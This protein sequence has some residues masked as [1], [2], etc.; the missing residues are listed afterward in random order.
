MALDFNK[1]WWLIKGGYDYKL[2]LL[3]S[4]MLL[5]CFTQIGVSWVSTTPQINYSTVDSLHNLPFGRKKPPTLSLLVFLVTSCLRI[6]ISNSQLAD[7]DRR[8]QVRDN[9]SPIGRT[10]V[11]H[12]LPFIFNLPSKF[13]IKIFA[14]SKKKKHFPHPKIVGVFSHP[15]LPTTSLLKRMTHPFDFAVWATG[16]A[17]VTIQSITRQLL[18]AERADGSCGPKREILENS[19]RPNLF[20]CLRG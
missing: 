6:M 8:L 15:P 5:L 18:E 9:L 10:L 1:G 3:A 12:Q 11:D 19:S 4:A 7:H 14:I 2:F 17:L 20:I 16:V 13:P